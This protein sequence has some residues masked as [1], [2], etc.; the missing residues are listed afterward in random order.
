MIIILLHCHFRALL[1]GPGAVKPFLCLK[2]GLQHSG[3]TSSY[4]SSSSLKSH[5][6]APPWGQL[7]GGHLV[8]HTGTSDSTAVLLKYF[9]GLEPEGLQSEC[10]EAIC[11]SHPFLFPFYCDF[12][13]SVSA[14]ASRLARIPPWCGCLCTW[15]WRL[16][17]EKLQ[18]GRLGPGS[19]SHWALL[20]SAKYK[21]CSVKGNH[22]LLR[23]DMRALSFVSVALGMKI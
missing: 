7:N 8:S 18:R 19:L 6:S 3:V 12:H 14:C 16:C 1:L 2:C 4:S 11:R 10:L 17:S 13:M 20:S 21:D 22:S 23:E 15:T 5:W 9:L